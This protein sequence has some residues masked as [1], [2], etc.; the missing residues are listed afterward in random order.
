MLRRRA[1]AAERGQSLVLALAFLALFTLMAAS[2]LSFASTVEYQRGS[3]ERT[4]TTNS[5]AQG[6]A[7]F[8]LADTAKYPCGQVTGGSLR[9]PSSIRADTL[10]YGTQ[11]GSPGG[12]VSCATVPSGGPTSGISC[13]LCLLNNLPSPNA[14]VTV[15]SVNKA[16]N[17]APRGEIDANGSIVGSG[18]A[19]SVTAKKIALYS[20][21]TCSPAGLCSPSPTSSASPFSDPLAGKLATPTNTGPPA[22]QNCNPCTGV[23][24][25]GVFSA[26]GVNNA[27]VWMTAGNYIV[28]GGITIAGAA[29]GSLSNTDCDNPSPLC[30]TYA[31][32]SISYTSTTVTD[33]SKTW[34]ASQWAGATV[35]A[36]F[37]DGTKEQNSVTGNSANTLTLGSSWAITPSAGSGYAVVAPVVIYLACPTSSAPHYGSCP[38]DSGGKTDSGS[39]ATVTYT[40]NSLTDT[41][42]SWVPNQWT[43]A[44]VTATTS[45]GPVTDTVSNNTSTTLTLSA[46]WA[47]TPK[48]GDPYTLATTTYTSTTLTD[49]SK[50]WTLGQWVGAA[51]TVTLSN[52]TTETASVT[53][54]TANTLTVTPAW[55]TLPATGN[56]YT[57]SMTGGYLTTTGNGTLAVTAAQ[58]GPYAGVALF[59]DPSLPDPAAQTCDASLKAMI[60]VAGNGGTIG[61]TIYTPKGTVDIAGGGS[62][63]SGVT[64]DGYLVVRDLVISGNGNSKLNLNGPTINSTGCD[65]YDA[66]VLGMTAP[67]GHLPS[68][69]SRGG[70]VQFN[71]TPVNPVNPPCP[72]KT[73]IVNFAYAP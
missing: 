61:G 26:I 43:G 29:G 57:L 17:I 51:V 66:P 69:S 53:A 44:T 70:Q 24:H 31:N 11:D 23:I 10:Q 18:G 2:V 48:A 28:T 19:A 34:T 25:P 49:A 7:Q 52:G 16:L 4:A 8:A 36:T 9:F 1:R 60:C 41:A 42:K 14:A 27:I 13:F 45:N 73:S 40:K 64:V 35:T 67:D 37:S 3:T 21:A 72:S 54:N 32:A 62:T 46:N 47:H 38:T 59:T 12:G 68:G 15:L 22:A 5:A 6:A 65:Y 39:G 55:T 20:G 71:V 63:G 56:P 33:T 58:T 50:S 30:A